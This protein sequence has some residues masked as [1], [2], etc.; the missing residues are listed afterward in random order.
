MTTTPEEKKSI[1]KDLFIH[2]GYELRWSED[3]KK[4][5]SLHNIPLAPKPYVAVEFAPP[6]KLLARSNT[7]KKQSDDLKMWFQKH[8]GKEKTMILTKLYRDDKKK[9]LVGEGHV[10]GTVFYI[11]LSLNSQWKPIEIKHWVNGGKMECIVLDPKL[12]LSCL[13]YAY[14]QKN[15]F[16]Y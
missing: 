13:P 5:L 10:D 8:Q 6:P 11:I 3:D 15:K 7:D 16:V 12:R 4:T 1:L 2:V 9:L 14:Q